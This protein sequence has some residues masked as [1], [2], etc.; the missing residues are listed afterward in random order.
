M[1]Q[2]LC[3]IVVLSGT[4]IGANSRKSEAANGGDPIV[5]C[6]NWYLEFIDVFFYSILSIEI[7]EFR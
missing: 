6:V 4:V 3:I 5:R 2:F 7:L 1:K